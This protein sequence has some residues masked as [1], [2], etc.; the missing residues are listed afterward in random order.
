MSYRVFGIHRQSVNQGLNP[1]Y[2]RFS[3]FLRALYPKESSLPLVEFLQARFKNIE[4]G[5]HYCK[6]LFMA[7][8]PSWCT[9]LRLLRSRRI[10]HFTLVLFAAEHL[11]SDS[12]GLRA[13][14]NKKKEKKKREKEKRRNIPSREVPRAVRRP[15]AKNRRQAIPSRAGRQNARG[16]RHPWAKNRWQA[17]PSPR[18]E[19]EKAI[20]SRQGS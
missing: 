4:A 11:M 5:F 14:R 3:F 17:I 1:V 19:T 8:F 10:S 2:P 7:P 16:I 9:R 12:N 18:R 6:S 20:P 15:R 13:R